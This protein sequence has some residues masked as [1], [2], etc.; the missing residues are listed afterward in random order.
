MLK[1]LYNIMQFYYT[2]SILDKNEMYKINNTVVIFFKEMWINFKISYSNS[3]VLKYSLWY[4]LGMAAYI[5]VG[6]TSE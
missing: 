2:Y 3:T 4:I 1:Q 5:E 6:G